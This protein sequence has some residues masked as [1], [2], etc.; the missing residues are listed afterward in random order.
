MLLH[1]IISS[2]LFSP[3][4]H[5]SF[6]RT[7]GGPS[8]V[9]TAIDGDGD[10]KADLSL[11]GPDPSKAGHYRY[12][13]LTSGYDPAPTQGGMEYIYQKS[14]DRRPGWSWTSPPRPTCR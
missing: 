8:D 7:I 6:T 11:Y 12:T 1:I 13:V 3:S 14:A 5:V 9:P 10:G 4:S 2:A